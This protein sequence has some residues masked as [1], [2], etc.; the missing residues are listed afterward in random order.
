[1][2]CT[3]IFCLVFTA[4]AKGRV[5]LRAKICQYR[6]RCFGKD[7]INL[8]WVIY[9]LTYCW[10]YWYSQYVIYIITIMWYG[11][12]LNIILT[13]CL[14]MQKMQICL[15]KALNFIQRQTHETV[16]SS[17][18]FYVLC[19]WNGPIRLQI[20]QMYMIKRNTSVIQ[21]YVLEIHKLC[22]D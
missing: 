21:K 3:V 10:E 13:R 5:E 20:Q 11:K 9:S 12:T 7:K 4:P 16:I 17:S 19:L 2:I 8:L 15:W 1:M 18:K 22:N 14:E 6:N